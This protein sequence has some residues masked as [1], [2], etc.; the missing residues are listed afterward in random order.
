MYISILV[1]IVIAKIVY[2]SF[3]S[4]NSIGPN[5]GIFNPIRSNENYIELIEYL[6]QHKDLTKNYGGTP[7]NLKSS[8][9]NV[10]GKRIGENVELNYTFPL[11]KN[12]KSK[13]VLNLEPKSVSSF[14]STFGLPNK[15][16]TSNG[17]TVVFSYPANEDPNIINNEL[18]NRC[19]FYDGV[20]HGVDYISLIEKNSAFCKPIADHILNELVEKKVDSYFNRVQAVLNFVQFIPYGLPEFDAPGWCYFGIALPAESF[21]LNYSDCDSKSIFFTCILSHLIGK[22]NIA[23]VRCNVPEPHMM[24]A[25]H[26]LNIQGKMVSSDSKSYLLLETT[27]PCV[28]GNF[29]SD[30]FEVKKIITFN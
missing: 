14:V 6:T 8:P 23:L 27:T 29:P 19:G 1:A 26:G 16:Y 5:Q 30:E 22:E 20:E 21:I 24:T 12:I 4:I 2:L 28:I 10:I 7:E 13:M 3:D 9:Y 18:A 15:Y 17:D 11:V 25:I